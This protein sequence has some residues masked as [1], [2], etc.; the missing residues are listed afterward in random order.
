VGKPREVPVEGAVTALLPK[1]GAA[2]RVAVYLEGKRAFEV[3]ASVVA[4][5]S[6]SVGDRISATERER[7]LGADAPFRARETALRVLTARDRSRQEVRLRLRRAEFAP[8]L[9]EETIAWLVDRGYVDDSRFASLYAAEK[10]RGG[11][12]KHRIASELARK[13]VSRN[14]IGEV[15]EELSSGDDQAGAGVGPLV[16][17]ARRRFGSQLATDPSGAARRVAGFLGRRGYDWD[18]IR[19]VL[20]ELQA[21]LPGEGE[22]Q[23]P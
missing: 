11:W 5:F 21:L 18:T 16:E 7:L 15:L 22:S 23:A 8:E 6:L 1:R 12:G 14:V 19:S 13:G 4:A 9:V 3:G 17:L 10:A 20:R 2:D